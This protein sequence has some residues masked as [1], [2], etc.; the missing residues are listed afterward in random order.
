MAQDHSISLASTRS[1]QLS[2]QNIRNGEAGLNAHRQSLLNRVPEIGDWA[3]F[4]RNSIELVD[5]AYL[6][7]KS[8]HEFALL[9]G[10]SSDILFHGSTGHCRF[11][12]E[13]EAIIRSRQ[14]DIIVHSHPGEEDPQP[15]AEDRQVLREIGQHTSTVVSGITG[16]TRIFTA[17]PFEI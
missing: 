2:L 5:L 17:D 8:G 16:L 13:L 6:S 4:R 11:I 12:G 14:V 10:K 1:R 7:A 15:S 3:A 9:R